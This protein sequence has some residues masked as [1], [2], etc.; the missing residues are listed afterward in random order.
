[1]HGLSELPAGLW[2]VQTVVVEPDA[3]DSQNR[4]SK[5]TYSRIRDRSVV[6]WIANIRSGLAVRYRG[7]CRIKVINKATVRN[8]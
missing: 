2:Q 7:I 8:R 1:M 6:T 3:D 4:N 5:V